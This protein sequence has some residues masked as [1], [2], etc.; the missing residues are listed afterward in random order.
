M[1]E[2]IDEKREI[3]LTRVEPLD[4]ESISHFL[5]RFRREKGNKFSAPSGLGQVVGFGAVLVRWEKFY[6]NPF[7]TQQ[8]LEALAVVVELDADRL[9]Q[10]LPP[11]GGGMNHSPI[12]LCGACYRESP[13]HKIE[14][15]AKKTGGCDRHQLRLLSKCPA[16][17]KPFPIPA[18]WA[19]GLCQK[20]FIPFAEMTKYQKAY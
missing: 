17:E 10:M 7:P 20:C 6:F 16:C 14:W 9:R 8:E 18:L 2:N 12:R 15:Q 11:P 1:E 13:C 4:G 5:G 19:E 3:W